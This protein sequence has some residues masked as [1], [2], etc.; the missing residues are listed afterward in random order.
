MD[1]SGAEARAPARCRCRRWFFLI[2]FCPAAVVAAAGVLNACRAERLFGW[3]DTRELA[4]EWLDA[5]ISVCRQIAIKRPSAML[6]TGAGRRPLSIRKVERADLAVLREQYTDYFL[7]VAPS[8]PRGLWGRLTRAIYPEPEKLSEDFLNGSELLCSWAPLPYHRLAALAQ[9]AVELYGLKHVI[10]E[11]ALDIELPQPLRIDNY[12]THEKDAQAFFPIGHGLGA[13]TGILIDRRPK[14]IAVGGPSAPRGNVYLVLNTAERAAVVLVRGFGR[15]FRVR[16]NPYD[17]AIVPLKRPSW[18]PKI[19]QFE[20]IILRTEKARGVFYVPCFARVA[21]SVSEASRIC[22]ELGHEET[23]LKAFAGQELAVACDPVT[24][25]LLAVRAERWDLA[26]LLERPAEQAWM[27]L[28]TVIHGNPATVR[29][30]GNS[31]YYYNEFSRIRIAKA[32]DTVTERAEGGF[33]SGTLELPV[34]LARGVYELS[35][36]FMIRADN[37]ADSEPGEVEFYYSGRPGERLARCETGL[38]ER[39]IPFNVRL[40]AALETQPR[41]TSRARSPLRICFRNL[42]ISWSLASALES[43]RDDFRCARA[44]HAIA[45]GKYEDARGYLSKLDPDDPARWNGLETRQLDFACW[46]GIGHPEI[47]PY[48][49]WRLRQAA[50]S[51]YESLVALGK[52]NSVFKALA[53]ELQ[54]NLKEPVD[55]GLLRLVGFKM[56][57]NFA[58]F[59]WEARKNETPPMAVTF[60]ARQRGKWR[61][62]QSQPLSDRP[63]L[64]RGERVALTVRLDEAFMGAAP[65]DI[66]IGVETGAKWHPGFVPASGR[67]NGVIT[68]EELSSV[69]F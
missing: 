44:A 52:I 64:A 11:R 54:G 15:S 18:Q 51:H 45:E 25:Y 48:T 35:G 69:S 20:E 24:A 43:V 26:G 42:E 39:W 5:N 50:R 19:R 4:R 31:G 12:Y 14:A 49:A 53:D 33:Y 58:R 32:P 56:D 21:F 23:A 68:L 2:L 28:E 60:W 17:A 40:P 46:R 38:Q 47:F 27:P 57:G 22:L 6:W 37:A 16:L 67:S 1:N 7:N 59:V 34:R 66:A 62:K 41:I 10:R 29:I 65:S 13:A 61:K 9:P 55:F 8:P 36:E 63:L 30:N 3:T